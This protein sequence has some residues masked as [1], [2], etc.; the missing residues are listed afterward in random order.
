MNDGRRD[1]RADAVID[2]TVRDNSVTLTVTGDID[3]SNADLLQSVI[4]EAT[5]EVPLAGPI[6]VDLTGVRL[7]DSTGIGALVNG[8]Q[9]A[10]DLGVRVRV[11]VRPGSLVERVLQIVGV[12]DDLVGR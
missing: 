7:M 2:W 8:W 6:L 3:L 9:A 10:K 1:Q 12:Y 4:T 11:A 5:A